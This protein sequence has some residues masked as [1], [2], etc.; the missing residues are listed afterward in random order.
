M[1]PDR[2]DATNR[3]ETPEHGVVTDAPGPAG[4]APQPAAVKP[5]RGPATVVTVMLGAS[6]LG[7]VWSLYV[8]VL[9]YD[10]A[11]DARTGD[12]GAAME[13]RAASIDAMSVSAAVALA[14]LILGTAAAFI[15]WFHRCRFNSGLFRPDANRMGQG[16]AIGAWFVPVANLWLPK[17]I[18]NDIWAAAPPLEDG[19]AERPPSKAV[20]QLWWGLWLAALILERFAS[21][22]YDSAVQ[23]EEISRAALVGITRDALC[24]LAA[25]AAI[26]VVWRLT[27]LQEARTARMYGVHLGEPAPQPYVPR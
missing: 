18:A 7:A 20:L 4:W 17:K 12:F 23:I 9:L 5:V 11:Q 24:V 13:S 3:P 19:S 14:V 27:G 6:A 21:K 22:M 25:G 16:W 15:V 1:D 2:P 10:F 26:A 8:G